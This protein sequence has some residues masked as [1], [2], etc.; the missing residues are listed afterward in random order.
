[1]KGRPRNTSGTVYRRPKKS[2]FWWVRY[3]DRNGQI[4]KE[5]ART[6]DREEAER[7]LRDR[8]NARDDGML[9]TIL[10]SKGL[11]FDE[12]A[13][14]FLEKRSKPPFREEKTHRENLKA[15]KFLGPVFGRLRLCDITSEL[16][17]QYI[18]DRLSCRR[19]VHTKFGVKHLGRLKPATVH[20][21]FRVLRRVLNLAVKHKRLVAN[22]CSSVEFPVSVKD[23]TR[24]PHYMT[25]SEQR[26]IEFCAPNHLRHAIVILVETGLR[27]YRE[28]MCMRKE[29]VDLENRMV[30]IPSSKTPTGVA[31]MPMTTLARDAFKAQVE[32]TPSSDYLFPSPSMN[33]TKPHILSLRTAWA[34]TLR[35]AGVKYF[36]LYELRHTFATRLSAGGVADHFVTQ[37]LRQSDSSV[38]KRYSQAKLAMMREALTRLDRQA[39][40]HV[41][42][43]SG[44]P[45]PN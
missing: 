16:I 6:S 15:V 3:R 39:N 9:Q 32:A 5:S 13:N 20:Q 35:R 18:E 17:E 2:K 23:S 34:A 41:T 4:V 11:T 29:Q 25:A 31:D 12:W 10:A 40:E 28:L 27:P 37:L 24:K 21:E 42:K 30:H 26:R 1:M 36:S 19:R 7:F 44:T 38:F 22:P 45:L 43:D 33:A 8:L 14:W